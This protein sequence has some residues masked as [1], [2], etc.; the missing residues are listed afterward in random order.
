MATKKFKLKKVIA[1]N[2]R[3]TLHKGQHVRKA[4]I[5]E[6]KRHAIHTKE[7]SRQK[8]PMS[9]GLIVGIIMGVVLLCSTTV[10]FF[11]IKGKKREARVEAYMLRTN[12]ENAAEAYKAIPPM[13][14]KAE[15]AMR[16]AKRCI[17]Q[18][19]DAVQVVIGAP[20]PPLPDR[21]Q[22]IKRLKP[23]TD[24]PSETAS[25]TSETNTGDPEPAKPAPATRVR[26]RPPPVRQEDEVAA[27]EGIMSRRALEMKR[28]STASAPRPTSPPAAKQPGAAK[29]PARKT[30]P[31]PP[32]SSLSY[33]PVV[34]AAHSALE[35][36][37]DALLAVDELA[38]LR[39]E[40]EMER[41]DAYRDRFSS[42]V[43]KRVRRIGTLKQS[44]ELLLASV[45]ECSDDIR[46]S[47]EKVIQIKRNTIEERKRAEKEEQQRLKQEKHE[48]LIAKEKASVK[49]LHTKVKPFVE[50][51]DF[52]KQLNLLKGRMPAM[53]TDEGKADLTLLIDRFQKLTNLK[54]FVVSSLNARPFRWGW[55]T[56]AQTKDVRGADD[57]IVKVVGADVPWEQVS[58]S[59]F[60][61][62]VDHYLAAP[63]L[64]ASIKG[65]H[66]LAVGIMY[67]DL[68]M[69][70]LAAKK[71]KE[72]ISFAPHMRPLVKKLLLEY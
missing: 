4:M 67:D 48:A 10:I 62:F 2:E 60:M 23:D 37:E 36:Y 11:Y 57:T 30:Q 15:D 26:R 68:G 50:Q 41:D 40:A 38:S 64:K 63:S 61:K 56:G 65:E 13:L 49:A 58:L 19:K 43:D 55:G 27:P 28:S 39:A 21:P 31:S 42:D 59:Q 12:R 53:R 51:Y 71:G 8:K 29:T 72:A 24:A 33:P 18:V 69:A 17:D 47:T 25:A 70:D 9:A 45:T 6:G 3:P 22:L 54:N 14:D 1:D 52:E 44:S 5:P 20:V 32:V 66:L 7:I 46:K 16:E 34:V 35:K